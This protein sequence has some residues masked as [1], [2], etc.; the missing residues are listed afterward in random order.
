MFTSNNRW[1]SLSTTV[2]TRQMSFIWLYLYCWR[3]TFLANCRYTMM[4]LSFDDKQI[5]NHIDWW[6]LTCRQRIVLF[7]FY[8]QLRHTDNDCQWLLLIEGGGERERR[9]KKGTLVASHRS[10]WSS[11]S[12]L[13]TEDLMGVSSLSHTSCLYIFK[14]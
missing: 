8:I 1:S 10:R 13:S 4:N 7:F 11:F 6:T 3:K 12:Y 9:K 2:S 14:V 5:A